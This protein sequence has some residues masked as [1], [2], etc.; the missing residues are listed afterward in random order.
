MPI[1][2][3]YWDNDVVK[4][5]DQTKLPQELV[6]ITCSTKED[7]WH[8]IKT[9]Q[10]R[11]APAI[12]I[13]AGFGVFLGIKNFRGDDY[14]KFRKNLD[15][16][17]TYLLSVR[18]TAVNLAWALNRM[19][20]AVE[21]C[22]NKKVDYLKEILF[23]EAQKILEEDKEICRRMARFG[24]RLIKTGCNVLTHCN[25]GGLATADYGTALGVLFRAKE[26]GKKFHVYVD[27]T[28]P[29]L[30]GARLTAWE[31]MQA[32]IPC[33]LISDNMAASLMKDKKIDLVIVGGDRIAGNGDTANKIGTY[34][35]ACL[36]RFHKIPFYVAA[37]RSSFDLSIKD[38]S[39][40]PIEERN[41]DEI[42]HIKGIRI[43]PEGVRV[44]NPSF[45]ITSAKYITSFI[46]ENGII[47]PSL[48]KNIQQK[49]LEK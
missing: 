46:T 27:E 49:F 19:R 18:P 20:R 45:D 6:Y 16:V 25:A 14:T 8:A 2:T 33:T 35:L 21:D 4:L 39:S 36:A 5:I 29:V 48:K 23:K 26:E 34:S 40:I 43:A 31:L 22:A 41:S 15:E 1:P 37:P 32:G 17:I 11:G 44:Y 47:K 9:M 10:I 30:Q 24:A 12:G 7:I 42:T 3:I 38:G 28:R 13:A